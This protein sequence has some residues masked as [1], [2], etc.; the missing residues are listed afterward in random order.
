M[1]GTPYTENVHTKEAADFIVRQVD[2]HAALDGVPFSDLEK[3]RMYFTEHGEPREDIV[4]LE[5]ELRAQYDEEEF[6]KKIAQLLA[7]ACRR[8]KRRLESYRTWKC[9][10]TGTPQRR[11]L[12]AGFMDRRTI[13][14]SPYDSRN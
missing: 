5:E 8:L 11:L 1:I 9:R 2:D 3:R 12:S 7:G 14:R 4:A 13:E 10:S 6:E